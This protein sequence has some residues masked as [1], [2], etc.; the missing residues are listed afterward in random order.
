MP[1][2]HFRV[3][4]G[5]PL[6]GDAVERLMTQGMNPAVSSAPVSF[7]I[8]HTTQYSTVLEV[9]TE[10][11]ELADEWARS[12]A[13]ALPLAEEFTPVAIENPDPPPPPLDVW[14]KVGTW[15]KTIGQSTTV[16]G[17]LPGN[18]K[19][20]IIWGSGLSGA[21]IG[22]SAAE[23]GTYCLGF[24]DGT[25]NACTGFA[26]QDNLATTNANRCMGDNVFHLLDPAGAGV[27][28]IKETAQATFTPSN[29]FTLT[30]TAT[31]LAT[32]GFYYAF[33]GNDIANVLV[34][35]FYTAVDS[36]T[37]ETWD[38]V[39]F[40]PDFGMVLDPSSLF[41]SNAP[42][43]NYFDDSG[44]AI[45]DHLF[46]VHASNT[47]TKTFAIALLGRDNV[48]SSTA[49]STISYQT[50]G[51]K[52]FQ[53]FAASNGAVQHYAEWKGWTSTGFKTLW[54]DAVQAT[55]FT[56]KAGLFVK[57]GH[58]DAGAFDQPHPTNTVTQALW[59]ERSVP[60]GVMA[61]SINKADM[62]ATNTATAE[63]ALVAGAQDSS[64]NKA[65]I[66]VST[67][68]AIS[69]SV[70]ATQMVSDK[71]L[72]HITADP[73]AANSVLNAEAVISDMST[74]AQF[75]VNYTTT[76]APNRQIVWFSL[77]A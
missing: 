77:S 17:S 64:G 15:T 35:K 29:S 8:V 18:V 43:G 4:V 14:A 62:S 40:R 11:Q 42:T 30:W 57:G 72:K 44:T 26:I 10:T 5:W 21:T 75:T 34:S 38:F 1:I 2:K 70:T 22:G 49:G 7:H 69:P 65:C 52:V 56:V 6:A 66:T 16:I 58:W 31:T 71:F 28:I 45:V 32:Q 53:D 9:E 13:Q 39:G 59:H 37:L 54:I 74:P 63:A 47:H 41:T 27:A 25:N 76:S 73:T 61:F 3:Q 55:G 24:S 19:G 50:Y 23:H 48:S 51:G 67:P 68:A 60:K 36:P 20:L 33:G 12:L 46:S